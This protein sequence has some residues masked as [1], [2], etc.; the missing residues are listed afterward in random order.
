M[1]NPFIHLISNIISILNLALIVWIVLDV[2]IQF[3]IVNRAQP[4]IAGIYRT[5]TK[6]FD[7]ILQPIRNVLQRF[8]PMLSIDLSPLVLILLMMF[9]EDA[10]YSWLYNI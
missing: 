7:P 4:L 8:L 10:M 1:L 5:L 6:L 9:I 2:L 3:N